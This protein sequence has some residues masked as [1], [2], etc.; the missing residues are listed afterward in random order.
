LELDPRFYGIKKILE[1][2]TRALSDLKKKL[3]PGLKDH[4]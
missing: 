1:P 4:L 2:V 3:E